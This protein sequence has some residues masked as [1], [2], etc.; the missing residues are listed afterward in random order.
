MIQNRIPKSSN[1]QKRLIREDRKQQTL[2]VKKTAT[3]EKEIKHFCNG[4]TDID[5]S[6]NFIREGSPQ[7]TTP[8]KMSSL[9]PNKEL[10]REARKT[11]A[12]FSH[13]TCEVV[14]MNAKDSM[15]KFIISER[16][17]GKS[18]KD[19][20]RMNLF[21]KMELLNGKSR[22][23]PP[24]GLASELTNSP[25]GEVRKSRVS[26]TKYV[27]SV[28]E[29]GI[30]E[31]NASVFS[32]VY[33]G[34]TQQSKYR[35][36][37]D[38]SSGDFSD[39]I[40]GEKFEHSSSDKVKFNAFYPELP[41]S[42]SSAY[43]SESQV[44]NKIK[45]SRGEP[46]RKQGDIHAFNV[47]SLKRRCKALPRKVVRKDVLEMNFDVTSCLD[48]LPMSERE[49][50][51]KQWKN[52]CVIAYKNVNKIT[53]FSRHLYKR[54]NEIMQQY[55]TASKI[56]GYDPQ[57][58]RDLTGIVFLILNTEVLWWFRS[59][60]STQIVTIFHTFLNDSRLHV[61]CGG[62]VRGQEQKYFSPL[63]TKLYFHVNSSRKSAIVFTSNMAALSRGCEPKNV[64]RLKILLFAN[65]SISGCSSSFIP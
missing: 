55:V 2:L 29:G 56:I 21:E 61:T 33:S 58:T 6:E 10:T 5:G 60:F 46:K 28:T 23:S 65:L 43:I 18:S 42:W 12:K 8:V 44:G 64:S 48:D 30:A 52:C 17:D 53:S 27:S 3:L 51:G 34:D 54:A 50:K 49:R 38:N 22:T 36:T 4:A 47:E 1:I 25:V 57:N 63:G 31:C 62:H 45:A 40:T 13:Q 41:N 11:D 15:K 20:Y 14:A 37:L 16:A 32:V 59:I 7:K 39:R 24:T 26:H 35:Q 9:L 19:G